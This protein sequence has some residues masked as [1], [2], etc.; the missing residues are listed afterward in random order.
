MFINVLECLCAGVLEL[1]YWMKRQ[2][3][4]TPVR[5]HFNFLK[6]NKYF[7]VFCAIVD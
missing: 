6:I 5:L 4:N 3:A 2:Y 1:N 7:V